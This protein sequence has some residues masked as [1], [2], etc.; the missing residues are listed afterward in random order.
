[1]NSLM[2][3]NKRSKFCLL[4]LIVLISISI[5]LTACLP[6]KSKVVVNLKKNSLNE[7][8]NVTISNV[9]FINNQIIVTGTNL[10]TVSNFKIKEGATQTALV[11]ESKTNTS[12]VANTISNVTFAVGKV[13][14]FIL[15]NA[16]AASTFTVDFSI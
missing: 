4:K 7:S 3:I 12:L 2:R 16:H 5:M 10:N 9:K 14:D 6:T 13:F 1:M 15:S 11:I 8:L